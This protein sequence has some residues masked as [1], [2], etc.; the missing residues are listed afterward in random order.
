MRSVIVCLMVAA[1]TS[2]CA[3]INICN[4]GEYPTTCWRD[5]NTVSCGCEPYPDTPHWRES[6]DWGRPVY[7]PSATYERARR[8]Y[9]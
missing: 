9:E 4:D 7:S 5:G 3:T 6:R 2:G 1:V 8:R